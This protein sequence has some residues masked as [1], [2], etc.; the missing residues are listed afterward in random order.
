[1]QAVSPFSIL[2]FK[3]LEVHSRYAAAPHIAAIDL[4]TFEARLHADRLSEF[5]ADHM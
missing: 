4:I 1:M 2:Q 5:L 3:P